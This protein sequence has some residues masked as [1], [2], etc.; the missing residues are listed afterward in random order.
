LNDTQA[1]NQACGVPLT[2]DESVENKD[3]CKLASLSFKLYWG[4]PDV[5]FCKREWTFLYQYMN[6]TC[7][8]LNLNQLKM[9]RMIV[10]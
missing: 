4:E 3:D 1:A 8:E 2:L 7:A 5:W 6:N 10:K 9:K